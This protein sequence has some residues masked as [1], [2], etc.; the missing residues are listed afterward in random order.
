MNLR[1]AIITKM[2]KVSTDSKKRTQRKKRR[3][4]RTS[5]ENQPL[6]PWSLSPFKIYEVPLDY[7]ERPT[8]L[9]ITDP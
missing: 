8:D 5:Q 3:K 6:V 1:N 4:R 9:N 2:N 7:V